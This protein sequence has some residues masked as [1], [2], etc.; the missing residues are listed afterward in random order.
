MKL[1]LYAAIVL[2]LAAVQSIF[3]HAADADE[4]LNMKAL[5]PQHIPSA[6]CPLDMTALDAI[7]DDVIVGKRHESAFRGN[8]GTPQQVE[9][10]PIP[11]AS[12]ARVNV[13]GH[14]DGSCAPCLRIKSEW[15]SLTD[16]Q[17]RTL[18]YQ[19]VFSDDVP[20]WVRATPCLH[21]RDQ[22]GEWH[23]WDWMSR[24]PIE[25]SLVADFSRIYSSTERF[26]AARLQQE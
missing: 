14:Y 24:G 17:R 16:E 5:D 8:S 19:L 21:W 15:E 20:Y 7:A 3:C 12:K 9:R 22:A 13:Y 2:C 26:V 10:N 23:R 11:A 6:A 18:P 25:Q 1:I 4:P